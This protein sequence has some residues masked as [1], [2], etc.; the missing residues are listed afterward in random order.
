MCSPAGDEVMIDDMP[1]VSKSRA[2][3]CQSMIRST[4]VDPSS[5]ADT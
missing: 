1:V 4:G 2:A 3:D 5:F